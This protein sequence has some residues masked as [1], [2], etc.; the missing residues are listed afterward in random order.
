MLKG[1][2]I[3]LTSEH[4]GWRAS[5]TFVEDAAAAAAAG[6]ADE[7]AGGTFNVESQSPLTEGEWIERVGAIVGWEG[8]VREVPA[9]DVDAD[10][11]LGVNFAQDVVVDGSRL[12]ATVPGLPPL[13]PLEEGLRRAV[14]GERTA[15]IAEG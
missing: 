10:L 13:V 3:A 2:D 14:E 9:A 8:V 1:E 15:L 11:D 4:I 6:L 5:R 12:R 7:A